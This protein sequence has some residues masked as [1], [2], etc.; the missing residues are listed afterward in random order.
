[1]RLRELGRETDSLLEGFTRLLEL[2]F[3]RELD[4]ALIQGLGR[5]E[6]LRYLLRGRP[7]RSGLT[8]LVGGA[9]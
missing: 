8:S 4:A 2:S 1:M 3:T 9:G 7:I 6:R 5:W